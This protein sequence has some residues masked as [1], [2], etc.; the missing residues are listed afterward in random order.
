MIGPFKTFVQRVAS[1]VRACWILRMI[2]A[3]TGGNMG[4][5]GAKDVDS[6]RIGNLNVEAKSHA[7]LRVSGNNLYL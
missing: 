6:K 3:G 1:R 7:L 2:R 4:G 5:H